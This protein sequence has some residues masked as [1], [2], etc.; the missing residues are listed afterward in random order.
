MVEKTVSTKRL[1]LVLNVNAPDVGAMLACYGL[2]DLPSLAT[3]E[4]RL[5][6]ERG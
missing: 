3:N 2:N 1:T 5:V 4:F 6:L